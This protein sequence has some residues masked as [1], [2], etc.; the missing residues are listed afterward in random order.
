MKWVESDKKKYKYVKFLTFNKWGVSS[1]IGFKTGERKGTKHVNFVSCK[2]CAKHE[3]RI[4]D[5]NVR[6][7]IKDAA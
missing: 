7:A 1:I 4:L 5:P 6:G 2:I 3:N